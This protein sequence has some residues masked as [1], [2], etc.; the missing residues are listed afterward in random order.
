MIWKENMVSRALI[1]EMINYFIA[2]N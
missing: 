1:I 2:R